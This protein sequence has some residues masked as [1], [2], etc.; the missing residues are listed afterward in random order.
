MGDGPAQ[1]REPKHSSL[2]VWQTMLLHGGIPIVIVGIVLPLGLIAFFLAMQN[3]PI[4]GAVEH[5]ELFLSAANAG[6]TGCLVLLVSRADESVN[7]L[8]AALVA[9]LLI[10]LPAFTCWAFLTAQGILDKDYSEQF[11]IIGGG[12]YALLATVVALVF[13]R[14]SYNPQIPPEN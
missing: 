14:L 13:V 2:G 4:K 8:I 9:L 6:F 3:E 5:G 1:Q 11:A 7:A 10:M 12:S